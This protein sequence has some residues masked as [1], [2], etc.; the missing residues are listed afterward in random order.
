[1]NKQNRQDGSAAIFAMTIVVGSGLFIMSQMAT[2]SSLALDREMHNELVAEKAQVKLT[3]ENA[4]TCDT[5]LPKTCKTGNP[6]ALNSK[7][8]T[9]LVTVDGMSKIGMWNVKVDCMNDTDNTYGIFV[10]R[11]VAQNTF[12]LDPQTK[13]PLNWK[14]VAPLTINCGVQAPDD[15]VLYHNTC[16]GTVTGADA[17]PYEV[18]LQCATV[19]P[20][21]PPPVPWPTQVSIGTVSGSTGGYSGGYNGGSSGTNPYNGGYSGG[22]SGTYGGSSGTYGGSSGS[23]SGS[24]GGY[25]GGSGGTNGG[26]YGSGSYG[27]GGGGGRFAP[28]FDGFSRSLRGLFN[29]EP[30]EFGLHGIKAAFSPYMNFVFDFGY[31][32]GIARQSGSSGSGGGSTGPSNGGSSYGTSGVPGSDAG[33]VAAG[34][35]CGDNQV[36]FPACPD[37]SH[38]VYRYADRFGWGGM[39]LS[40]YTLCK[41]NA[42]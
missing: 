27:G 30:A 19:P 35:Y 11:Q 16:Y 41:K 42:L 9:P 4:T 28:S 26:Y 20:A 33:C 14:S 2:R 1:M 40:K 39:D 17:L 25:G 18:A 24:S 7:S 38:V 5:P 29:A 3:L 23:Y 12:M 6:I 15:G 21:A 13:L 32:H 22:S 10:S 36:D 8:G 31:D 34:N 37:G